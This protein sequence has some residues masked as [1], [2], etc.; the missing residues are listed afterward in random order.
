VTF[1]AGVGVVLLMAFAGSLAP[2]LKALR[3]S[4]MSVMRAE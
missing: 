4:P 1:A 3:V 2:A